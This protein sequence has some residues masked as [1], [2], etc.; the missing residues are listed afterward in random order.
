MGST[1]DSC[2]VWLGLPTAGNP[3]VASI[4]AHIKQIV[5]L[6]I[7]FALLTE[8]GRLVVLYRNGEFQ[9]INKFC[10][11]PP[12]SSITEDEQKKDNPPAE[13]EKEMEVASPRFTYIVEEQ[14]EAHSFCFRRHFGDFL[15]CS[16][17]GSQPLL[18]AVRTVRLL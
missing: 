15:C 10:Q 6:G 14:D 9:L 3:P 5:C 12:L 4:P 1:D 17:S 2:S 8:E 18:S 7:K 11:P 13:M 16:M